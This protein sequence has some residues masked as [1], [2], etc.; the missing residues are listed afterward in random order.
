[1]K[2][3][4]TGRGGEYDTRFNL[5]AYGFPLRLKKLRQYFISSYYSDQTRLSPLFRIN[6]DAS[7]ISHF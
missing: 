5:S 2:K 1:M 3:S 6:I 4:G 7:R